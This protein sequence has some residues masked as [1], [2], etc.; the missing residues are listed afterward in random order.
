RPYQ[1]LKS[2][3]GYHHHC[4]ELRE[5]EILN[6][7]EITWDNEQPSRFINPLGLSGRDNVMIDSTGVRL[8]WLEWNPR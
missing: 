6:Q 1:S 2:Q 3:A 4:M 7:F 5:N 8:H